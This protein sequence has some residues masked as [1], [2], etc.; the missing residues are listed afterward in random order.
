MPVMCRQI[1][2]RQFLR[3]KGV[4]RRLA[5]K[6]AAINKE[7]ALAKKAALEDRARRVRTSATHCEM[8]REIFPSD[9]VGSDLG[10]A[11]VLIKYLCNIRS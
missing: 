1:I 11:G 8:M 2:S 4:R 7:R 9:F 10:N 3:I 5:E 6:Q